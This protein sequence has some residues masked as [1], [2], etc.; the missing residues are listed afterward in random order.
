MP[1]KRKVWFSSR[2]KVREHLSL[3]DLSKE[4][5]ASIWYKAVEVKQINAENN[6]IAK[7]MM[8]SGSLITVDDDNYCTHGLIIDEEREWY[9][10][11][12]M[13]GWHA[14]LLEQEHQRH[15]KIEDPEILADVYFD[16]TH[17]AQRLALFRGIQL[18]KELK[19][20]VS[21][22]AKHS[23]HGSVAVG[24]RPNRSVKSAVCA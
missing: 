1:E 11:K 2:V 21:M 4:D 15:D 23:S 10:E 13:M 6:K 22:G 14:V 24:A 16:H 9:R 12:R 3:D 7:E 17:E 8:E 20:E 19:Q 18:A 5:C